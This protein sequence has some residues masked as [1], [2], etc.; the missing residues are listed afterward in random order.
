MKVEKTPLEGLFVVSPKIHTDDRG[1][2]W[3]S[4]NANVFKEAGLESTFV[5][6]N[7]SHSRRGVLRG[8][9]FQRSPEAQLK[10][11]RCLSGAIFD[12]AVDLRPG[13]SSYAK[14]FAIILTGANRKMLY[15]PEG[16]A[17]GFLALTTADVAYK[18]NE[19]Y[20]QKNESGIRWDDPGVDIRWPS[21]TR[22]LSINDRDR[23]WPL[24]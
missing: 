18:T 16:F 10:L 12:V 14:W 5:Q 19:Y 6:D 17:H 1:A 9:H 2:F 24:I 7:H 11:V 20:S 22:E 3:E 21:I 8:L 13:S 4:Y 15:I 23:S